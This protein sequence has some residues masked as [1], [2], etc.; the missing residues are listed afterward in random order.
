MPNIKPFRAFVYEDRCIKKI[1]RLVCPPYDV[2]SS[3]A[4]DALVQKD[5]HNFIR[6][7]LPSGDPET[8]YQDAAQIW[9]QWNDTGVLKRG[10]VPAY[11]VY[12]VTFKS[13][14]DARTLVRRGFFA[15][16]ETVPWG[17]G[18]FPHEKTL[19]TARA[20]RFSLFKALKA[21]TSPIQL[22]VR[23]A[24]GKIESLVKAQTKGRPRLSFRDDSGVTHR[25]WVWKKGPSTLALEK[26][27][28]KFPC[29][30]ADGHHRYETSLAY[31]QWASRQKGDFLPASRYVMAFFS[32]SDDQGLEVLPT[33]RAVPWEK[34]SFVNLEKWGVL[35][36]VSGLKA[37]LPLMEGKKGEDLQTVGVF[38]NGTYY[39]YRF[40]KVPASLRGTPRAALAVT[41]L[42]A[43]PLKGLGKEDFFFTRRPEDAV[44][45]AQ[46][47]KGWAFFLAPNTVKEILDVAT[48]GEV[49]P[50][51]STYFYPKI[52][53]GLV[54]HALAGEL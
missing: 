44:S 19:P 32:S 45:H 51:K 48:A 13:Q 35:E 37:L 2:V 29:A 41:C 25:F 1:N 21:Q 38:R 31:G 5:P 11:Y 28:K 10:D 7:E 16:L 27:M 33:H 23:D 6:V 24:S 20:D 18:V 39:R 14:K 46:K 30:I 17:D 3:Q 40:N 52:P 15:A 34:R 53:S 12:E 4:R 8:R 47:T 54:S 43:G 9:T 49:M 22:L 26:W 42:H 50:P 36:P